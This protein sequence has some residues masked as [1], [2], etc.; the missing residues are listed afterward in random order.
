MIYLSFRVGET[1]RV[2][3]TPYDLTIVGRKFGRVQIRYETPFIRA[4]EWWPKHM[5]EQR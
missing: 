3:G 5:L 2:R 4:T 1:C